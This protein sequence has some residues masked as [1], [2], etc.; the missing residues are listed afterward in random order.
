[1]SFE[2]ETALVNNERQL[3]IDCLNDEDFVALARYKYKY[4]KFFDHYDSHFIIGNTDKEIILTILDLA[5]YGNNFK[6]LQNDLGVE[7]VAAREAIKQTLIFLVIMDEMLEQ[8]DKPLTNGMRSI[9]LYKTLCTIQDG[10][11]KVVFTIGTTVEKYEYDITISFADASYITSF[12]KLK[13]SICDI[14]MQL[15]PD[16]EH[17]RFKYPLVKLKQQLEW[18][19][20]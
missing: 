1:M 5:F 19:L 17:R 3:F 6:V 10:L 16:Y 4:L 18:L 15:A 7:V 9:F 20:S 11:D 14:D 8:F 2:K 13:R 12:D